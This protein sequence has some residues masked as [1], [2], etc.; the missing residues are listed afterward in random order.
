MSH[1][2][3]QLTSYLNLNKNLKCVLP[4]CNNTKK[5]LLMSGLAKPSYIYFKGH[6]YYQ[7]YLS[8]TNLSHTTIFIGN[9]IHIV[10]WSLEL[11]G[12]F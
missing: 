7:V 11:T 12:I 9:I 2:R 3:E 8:P 4:P 10:E 5:T 1:S 6:N